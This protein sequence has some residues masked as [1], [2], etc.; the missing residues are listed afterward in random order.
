TRGITEAQREQ[1][2]LQKW[3][4]AVSDRVR[5]SDH[6]AA[7]CRRAED[8]APQAQSTVPWEALLTLDSLV[9]RTRLHR[10][11]DKS[12][13][14]ILETAYGLVPAKTLIWV[15]RN[16]DAEVILQGESCLAPPDA[17]HLGGT[18][19]KSPEYRSTAPILYDRFQERSGAGRY[20]QVH[21]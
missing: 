2:M 7:T 18:L 11:F 6:L 1:S 4:Q 16:A 8:A 17:R 21:S 12:C 13:A 15:P 5:L 10:D 3:L 9:R 19:S 14:R 20:P